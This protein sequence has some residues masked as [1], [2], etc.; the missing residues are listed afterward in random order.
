MIKVHDAK[1]T[2][3]NYI[4]SLNLKYNYNDLFN[5][6]D[7]FFTTCKHNVEVTDLMENKCNQ[8]F[9]DKCN[10]LLKNIFGSGKFQMVDFKL[11]YKHD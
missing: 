10:D 6:K 11:K 9:N 4:Q 1:N 3:Y 5:N 8:E 2:I 7:V